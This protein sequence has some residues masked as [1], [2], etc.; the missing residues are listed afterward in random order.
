MFK[1]TEKFYKLN[2]FSGAVKFLLESMPKNGWGVSVKLAEFL[3]VTTPVMSQFVTGLKTPNSDQA[4][5][6]AKFFHLNKLETEFLITLVEYERSANH[7]SKDYK[8]QKLENLRLESKKVSQILNDNQEL[9]ESLKLKFYSHWG[10]SAVR[11]FCSTNSK[12]VPEDELR[13]HFPELKTKLS[14]ILDFLLENHLI[15]REANGFIIGPAKT[16][17]SKNSIHAVNHLRNWRMRSLEK[18]GHHNERELMYTSVMSIPSGQ[19]EY[20]LQELR[21][22]IKRIDSDSDEWKNETEIYC[23]NID[24][25]V[26]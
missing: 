13:K 9:N 11:L 20:V 14:E 7:Q 8:Y 1:I 19:I 17:V 15:L 18:S 25:F 5:Q 21:T 23:L 26:P 12:G 3:G 4:F 22:I 16:F 24:F 6:I 2:S 10:Y